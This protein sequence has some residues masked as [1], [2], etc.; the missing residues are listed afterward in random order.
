MK[1]KGAKAVH[2]DSGPN[3]TP[4][5][6]VVMVILI[7]L[8][9]AGSFGAAAHFLPSTTPIRAEGK[10]NLDPSKI[11]KVPDQPLEIFVKS[12][13]AAGWV[14]TIG[15]RN[16]PQFNDGQSLFAALNKKR[17]DHEATGS[18]ADKM[19][20]LISPKLQTRFD[21]IIQV[22]QAVMEAQWPKIGFNSARD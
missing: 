19:Q 18:T 11:P 21:H 3:M 7:F 16:G 10:G 13:G 1:I 20:I 14:A 5:V 15:G 6:D 8:M 17:L 9:L 2:Y 4:L 12:N 22:Y